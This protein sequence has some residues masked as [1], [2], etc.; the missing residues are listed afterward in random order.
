M[1]DR[2]RS[3]SL[4]FGEEY[5]RIDPK[6]QPLVELANYLSIPDPIG[7]CTRAWAT[8]TE[9]RICLRRALIFNVRRSFRYGLAIPSGIA[10]W[11]EVEAKAK[12]AKGQALNG[13]PVPDA[14]SPIIS[15][16]V[17]P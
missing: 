11:N 16:S 14:G 10:R 8:R 12:S 6:G 7:S 4:H 1:L 15:T 2:S 13:R 17:R 9:I 3:I 5:R